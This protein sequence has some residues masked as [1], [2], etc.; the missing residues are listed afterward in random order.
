MDLRRTLQVIGGPMDGLHINE[1]E[2]NQERIEVP[3]MRGNRVLLHVYVRQGDCYY[4]SPRTAQTKA[5]RR[6]RW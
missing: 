5:G 1:D 6:R 3:E 2:S 4:H